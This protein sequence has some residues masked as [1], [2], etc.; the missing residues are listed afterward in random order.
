MHETILLVL[1]NLRFGSIPDFIP[2]KFLSGRIVA[3]LTDGSIAVVAV[4]AAVCKNLLLVKF[5]FIRFCFVF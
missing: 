3:P 1:P 2:E 4:M 5:I